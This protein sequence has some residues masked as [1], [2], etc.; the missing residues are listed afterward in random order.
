VVSLDFRVGKAFDIRGRELALDLD[1][2]NVLNR[3]TVLGEQYDAA[4]TGSTQFRQPLEIMNPR[5]AR[6][7]VRFR[8]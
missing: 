8:F 1:L 3:S 2:F 7:G 5:L 6:I 4:A